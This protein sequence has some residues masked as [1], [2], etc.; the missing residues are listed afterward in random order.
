MHSSIR[1]PWTMLPSGRAL[2][3]TYPFTTPFILSNNIMLCRHNGPRLVIE[4]TR[5]IKRCTIMSKNAGGRYISSSHSM[6]MISS[7]SFARRFKLIHFWETTSKTWQ[8]ST[9]VSY[10]LVHY[11]SKSNRKYMHHHH[12]TVMRLHYTE[13]LF[14]CPD[15]CG[16]SFLDRVKQD[17]LQ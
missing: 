7:S 11:P 5:W 2:L 16:C 13:P 4:G 8:R 1:N 9:S 10:V 12:M 6:A 14:L 17:G 3:G 15:I